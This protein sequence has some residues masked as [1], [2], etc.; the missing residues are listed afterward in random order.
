MKSKLI[1]QRS[2]PGRSSVLSA[3]IAVA[4]G[5]AQP[6]LAQ[7]ASVDSAADSNP[8]DVIVT[9]GSRLRDTGMDL[10]NPVTVITRQEMTVIAPTNMIEGVSEL[11]QFYGSATTQAPSGFFTST[12]AGSL[13]LRGL[14][15]KRTLQLLDGRRVVPSTI[16][17]G[18]DVNLFPEN[19]VR[20]VDPVTGGAS[21][22]HDAFAQAV[23]ST[24][25]IRTPLPSGRLS[26]ST[27][28]P[29]NLAISVTM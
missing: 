8:I 19:V 14:Q 28:P 18:P 25:P 9:T 26:A 11:P 22:A 5:G 3:A 21:A 16:F 6:I 15:S 29:W 1:A 7:D 4:L 23:G 24:T 2:V 13:N 12:G 17:G 20:Q 10:P 27:R